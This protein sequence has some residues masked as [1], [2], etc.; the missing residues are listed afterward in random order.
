M[1]LA[2]YSKE[3]DLNDIN[4]CLIREERTLYNIHCFT[5]YRC[6]KIYKS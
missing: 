5:D 6:K 3:L 2:F 4:V 1:I